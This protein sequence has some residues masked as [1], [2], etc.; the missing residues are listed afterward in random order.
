MLDALIEPVGL[1]VGGAA[2]GHGRGSVGVVHTCAVE[3][4]W[5]AAVAATGSCCRFKGWQVGEVFH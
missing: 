4:G 3:A 2:V 1:G 5:G